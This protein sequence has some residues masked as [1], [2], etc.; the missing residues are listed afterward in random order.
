MWEVFLTIDVLSS[1]KMT[2]ACKYKIEHI[3]VCFVIPWNWTSS[4]TQIE[5]IEFRNSLNFNWNFGSATLNEILYS[6][7]LKN[8][9]EN[10]SVCQIYTDTFLRHPVYCDNF[11]L[12]HVPHVIKKEIYNNAVVLSKQSARF[13]C[14]CRPM[15]V[16]ILHW[17]SYIFWYIIFYAALCRECTSY[18]IE[19]AW[20][21]LDDIVIYVKLQK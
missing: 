17:R 7:I 14:I 8:K 9:F 19:I 20:S 15:N 16:F 11:W 21:F 1:I 13:T 5:V 6:F 4:C 2:H 3:G 10:T 12:R 18:Y